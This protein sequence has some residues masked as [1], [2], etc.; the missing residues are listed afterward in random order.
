MSVDTDIFDRQKLL[1]GNVV[2]L[3]RRADVTDQKLS[4]GERRFNELSTSI[5]E[6]FD[7]QRKEAKEREERLKGE[8]AHVDEKIDA[9]AAKLERFQWWFIGMAIALAIQI[10][11]WLF[12]IIG[13]LIVLYLKSRG[14]L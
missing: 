3:E 8:T 6:G 12:G 2:E 10:I 11:F 1:Q 4:D 7:L 9:V 13:A 14:D 5:K